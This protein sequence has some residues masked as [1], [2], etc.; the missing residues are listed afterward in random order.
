MDGVKFKNERCVLKIVEQKSK[1]QNEFKHANEIPAQFYYGEVRHSF[2]FC[3]FCLMC[4]FY[5]KDYQ[6]V[7][8]ARLGAKL[9]KR[10]FLQSF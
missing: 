7:E 4:R 9:N 1:V 2:S 5:V 3:W 8:E 10:I 6:D